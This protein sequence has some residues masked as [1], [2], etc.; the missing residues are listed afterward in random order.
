[1]YQLNK[2]NQLLPEFEAIFQNEYK[3]ELYPE[4][5][6]ELTAEVP[7]GS[8]S[9][10]E[11]IKWVQQSLNRILGL[12]LTEDGKSGTNTKNAIRSF[13]G[14]SGLK[15]DGIAGAQTEAAIQKALAGLST[16]VTPVSTPLSTPA[17]APTLSTLV[18]NCPYGYRQPGPTQSLSTANLILTEA[19][20]LLG[21]LPAILRRLGLVLPAALRFLDAAERAEAVTVFKSSLD[22]SRILISDGLGFSRRPFTI[23]VTVGGTTYVVMMLGGLCSWAKGNGQDSSTLI[24]ELVH[25]WQSQ[26][27]GSNPQAYMW[28]SILSQINAITDLP[29]AKAAAAGAVYI[30]RG[31][32]PYDPQT[33]ALA[34]QAAADEDVSAYAYIPGNNFSVYAAEQIAQQVE[35]A[36]LN[37]TIASSPIIN[38]IN[39]V[40]PNVQSMDNVMSL[41][42]AKFER[43]STPRVIWH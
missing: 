37:N 14:K 13:Q 19:N 1:M 42:A 33:I 18:I 34:A 20:N 9:S 43:K 24:H 5:E 2:H 35:D 23:A 26:H 39:S 28:N 29:T 21:R 6:F 7:G 25:A 31:F 11:Y 40:G 3:E 10:K 16:P 36:Y 22:F 4:L 32:N 12:R 8:R 38:I 41:S 17:P 15:Q 27:H 30:R